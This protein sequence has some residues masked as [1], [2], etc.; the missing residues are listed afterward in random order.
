VQTG[1]N[2]DKY[3]GSSQQNQPTGD[4]QLDSSNQPSYDIQG[5][6]GQP[7]QYG[8]EGQYGA[9]RGS[10]FGGGL[11][12]GPDGQPLRGNGGEERRASAYEGFQQDDSK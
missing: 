10:G 5:N 7:G 1:I 8:Q 6:A 4:P 11:A 12:K 3:L 9:V 2:V